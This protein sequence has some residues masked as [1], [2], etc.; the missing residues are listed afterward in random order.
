MPLI[1]PVAAPLDPEKV[2]RLLRLDKRGEG[3]AEARSLLIEAEALFRPRAFY[4]ESYVETR[5]E[6]AVVVDGRCFK[7]RILRQNI[8]ESF[9]VFPYVLTIGPELETRAASL[10]DPLRRYDLEVLA[11]AALEAAAETLRTRLQRESGIPRLSSMS[12]GSL[13]G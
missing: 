9:K 8:G 2:V 3:E 13:R 12:P 4:R 6:D 11:D 10:G 1:D 7:S 5:V